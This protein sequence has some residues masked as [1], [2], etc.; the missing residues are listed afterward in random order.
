[1]PLNAVFSIQLALTDMALP[2]MPN[3]VRVDG[4]FESSTR[5]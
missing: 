3:G 4:W 5:R 1:M 2:L